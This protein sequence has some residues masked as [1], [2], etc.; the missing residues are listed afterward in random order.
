MWKVS[1]TFKYSSIKFVFY[2]NANKFLKKFL[3]VEKV[4]YITLI[5]IKKGK[6]KFKN[7]MEADSWHLGYIVF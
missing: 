1:I 3:S 6:I 2:F 7:G 5:D 4:T